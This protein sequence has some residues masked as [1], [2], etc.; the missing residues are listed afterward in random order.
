MIEYFKLLCQF[1]KWDGWNLDSTIL[2]LQNVNHVVANF[3]P[4]PYSAKGPWNKS[5]NFIFPTKYV[6]P[7]NLKVS[8]WLSKF[9]FCQVTEEMSDSSFGTASED[10]WIWKP[11][12]N[13]PGNTTFF[14]TFPH[15]WTFQ[16]ETNGTPSHP[17]QKKK[18]NVESPHSF[19]GC[20]A[21]NS[22]AGGD[23]STI[24][25]RIWFLE[26]QPH[27][28]QSNQLYHKSHIIQLAV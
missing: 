20:L 1:N 22:S 21:L 9:P 24:T 26:Y 17:E 10:K 13:K 28:T 7:K 5:S 4:F 14:K 15:I 12:S 6:I 8:H 25:S 23:K 19:K 3:T 16:M 18:A 2:Q 27:A 11:Q